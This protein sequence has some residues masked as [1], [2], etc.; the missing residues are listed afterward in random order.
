M[1][2]LALELCMLQ[3]GAPR[4]RAHRDA[5]PVEWYDLRGLLASAGVNQREVSAVL[6][7]SDPADWGAGDH[8]DD[9]RDLRGELMLY[10]GAAADDDLGG[11]ARATLAVTPVGGRLVVFDAKVVLHE[12]MPHR[13]ER[14]RVALTSWIGGRHS[15]F[16]WLRRCGF[17]FR[18]VEV[19]TRDRLEAYLGTEPDGFDGQ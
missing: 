14:P 15:A 3:E 18:E 13:A 5:K 2:S 12:V 9:S 19:A 10:L 6:Y 17:T 1:H 11:S 7:L 8:A 16:E 4:Y